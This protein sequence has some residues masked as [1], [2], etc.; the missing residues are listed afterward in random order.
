MVGLALPWVL[1]QQLGIAPAEAF[2][3]VAGRLPDAGVAALM[4]NF[5]ARDDDTL[6]AFGWEMVTTA[7]GPDFR[8]LL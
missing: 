2:A 3:E 1:A 5:G 6:Q 8:P 7:E 4:R